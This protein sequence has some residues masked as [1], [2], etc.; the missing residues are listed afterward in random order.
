MAKLTKLSEHFTLD[1]FTRSDVASRKRI[2]NIPTD[3]EINTLKHTC[4]YLAEPLR[5]NLSKVF[6]KDIYIVITSGFRCL[7]LNRAL[8]SKDNSQHVKGE[9]FDFY[10]FYLFKGRKINIP[11]NQVYEAIKKLFKDKIISV[12]QCIEENSGGSTWVHV[13]YSAWG[14]TK[15]RG[16][17]LKYN[18]KT[19]VKDKV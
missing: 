2:I 4:E 5:A 14:K 1:E 16:E 13:S 18:G 7:K 6:G 9:A 8:G 12:D 10:C 17:F 11:Y 19:Y 3:L 15:N